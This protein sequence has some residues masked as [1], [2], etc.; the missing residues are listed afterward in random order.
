MLKKAIAILLIITISDCSTITMPLDEVGIQATVHHGD[1]LRINTHKDTT[2]TARVEKVTSKGIVTTQ[3]E[4]IPYNHI[5]TVDK[6]KVNTH[7]IGTGATVT[8]GVVTTI[9]LAPIVLMYLATAA[10]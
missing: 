9:V 5:K 3:G 2:F 6:V 8:A 1:K 7:L 4:L 10:I